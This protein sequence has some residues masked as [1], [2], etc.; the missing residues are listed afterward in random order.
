MVSTSTW[1]LRDS[2][3]QQKGLSTAEHMDNV[4]CVYLMQRCTAEKKEHSNDT[5]LTNRILRNKGK[6]E[7]FKKNI[8]DAITL[9]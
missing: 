2:H 7:F 6:E 4:G 3:R 9:I 8:N 1:L 5:D